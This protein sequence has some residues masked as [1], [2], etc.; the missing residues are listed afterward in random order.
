MRVQGKVIVVTGA[1]SGIGEALVYELLEKGA[2]IAAVDVR[3]EALVALKKRFDAH[4]ND[5]STHICDISDQQVVKKL[6]KA[7]I[8]AHGSVDGII[9][10]AGIIQ[11]FVKVAKLEDAA[12]EKVM[13]VNFYGTLGMVRA[14]LPLLQARPEAH[15]TN[16]SSMGGFL[17][18]PGQTVYGASKAAV[19][20]LSEGLYAELAGTNVQVMTVFP[21]AIATNIVKNSG[22]TVPGQKNADT[23]KQQLKPLPADKAARI[24]VAG[25]EKNKYQLFVGKDASLMNLLYRLSPRHATNFITKQMKTLLTD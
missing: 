9:N 12:I 4:S 1:G 25:I 22:V 23:Q 2:K 19:K 20:L 7:V 3:K 17:P 5:L 24:I 16:I 15:I 21:G 6:P 10:N 13:K 8:S 11:P 18:V 14:F